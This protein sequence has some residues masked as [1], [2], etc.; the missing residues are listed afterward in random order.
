MVRC[1]AEYRHPVLDTFLEDANIVQK[2]IAQFKAFLSVDSILSPEDDIQTVIDIAKSSK[3]A[4]VRQWAMTYGTFCPCRDKRLVYR[5]VGLSVHISGTCLLI[6]AQDVMRN[7]APVALKFMYNEE[8]WLREQHMRQLENGQLLDGKHVVQLLDA[9]KIEGDAGAMDSRL[10]GDHS[11]KYLLTMP[12]SKVR[13]QRRT[14]TQP[15]CRTQPRSSCEDIVP[16]CK[17]SSV[18]KRTLPAHSWRF[19]AAVR[20][21]KRF[22]SRLSHTCSHV[23]DACFIHAET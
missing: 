22:F 3:R 21:Q 10:K 5:L 15:L 4:D 11:Y 2:S 7:N 13:P 20:I 14:G 6:F 23:S 12:P 9:V 8:E 18:S 1:A 17:Q 19:E 16:D